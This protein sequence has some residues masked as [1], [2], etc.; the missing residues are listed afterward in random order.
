MKELRRAELNRVE[1][2]IGKN[3]DQKGPRAVIVDYKGEGEAYNLWAGR[4]S[5][6]EDIG[7]ELPQYKINWP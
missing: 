4:R 7:A 1:M 2:N 5:T 3:L 6:V